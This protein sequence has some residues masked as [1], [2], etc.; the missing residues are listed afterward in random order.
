MSL[1][2]GH[3]VQYLEQ[4]DFISPPT[5]ENPLAT[6]ATEGEDGRDFADRLRWIIDNR[7]AC[8]FISPHLDDAIL[9]S[10][11]LI[12]FLAQ[13][14]DVTIVTIFNEGSAKP[15]SDPALDWLQA[16][17][18]TNSLE[19]FQSREIENENACKEVQA[20]FMNLGFADAVFRGSMRRYEEQ[21]K[22]YLVSGYDHHY[23]Y[24]H[25]YP[26]HYYGDDISIHLNDAEY[27]KPRVRAK[28][29]DILPDCAP[30]AFFA[31]AGVGGHI[32][33]LLTRQVVE[34]TFI[35]PVF[36]F[37]FP[38]QEGAKT[39]IS[40]LGLHNYARSVWIGTSQAEGRKIKAISH[41]TSQNRAL[42]TPGIIDLPSE[43]YFSNKRFRS[44]DNY[45]PP[46]MNRF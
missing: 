20:G 18:H 32:D 42:F 16:S 9:S 28:L 22:P 31:P 5:V 7:V 44:K 41:Y 27:L 2:E 25:L 12:S 43:L 46:A 1:I 17:G 33:H 10:G 35:D 34:E 6:L 29:I 13:E 4:F 15:F 11:S 3:G 26:D 19:H 39:N 38:Y 36:W 30:I 40:S 14:T 23:E 37:D 24:Y 21:R 8:F 45:K